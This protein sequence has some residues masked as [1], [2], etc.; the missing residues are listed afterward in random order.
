MLKSY[1]TNPDMGEDLKTRI[2]ETARVLAT[3][4]IKTARPVRSLATE[5]YEVAVIQDG[6]TAGRLVIAPSEETKANLKKSWKLWH[7]NYLRENWDQNRAQG[8]MTFDLFLLPYK[9]D[10]D[11]PINEPHVAWKTDR[12]KVAQLVVPK[13]GDAEKEAT[14]EARVNQ[15][16]FQPFHTFQERSRVADLSED[17]RRQQGHT[18][19]GEFQR[20][21][22]A[23]YQ[24]SGADRGASPEPVLSRSKG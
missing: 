15:E 13:L 1:L 9:N 20:A 10:D 16:L 17:E 4:G 6:P 22:G 14:A 19:L 2:F 8:P 21:R 24:G 12:I 11:T 18:P 23:V 3:V 5:E 7:R